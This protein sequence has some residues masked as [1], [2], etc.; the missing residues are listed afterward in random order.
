MELEAA[1]VSL[2]KA[3]A[4]INDLVAG[5]IAATG[6]PDA[7]ARPNIVYQRIGTPR[8]WN[9]DG[10]DGIVRGTVQISCYADR[11]PQAKELA[12]AVR[13]LNGFRGTVT[14]PSGSIV[15]HGIFLD[16]ERDAPVPPPTGQSQGIAGIV[17]IFNVDYSE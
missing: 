3:D 9:N 1:I 8:T 14:G 12:K 7:L 6:L 13:A 10:P 11:Y 5:R 2:L 4:V 15:I 17:L 16:D